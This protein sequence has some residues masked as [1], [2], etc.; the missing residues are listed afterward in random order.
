MSPSSSRSLS[1]EPSSA[2][3]SPRP[4][5]SPTALAMA[6]PRADPVRVPP[7]LFVPA[8]DP[9]P[10]LTG[11]APEDAEDPE[12]AVPDLLT[13]AALDPGRVV[14]DPVRAPPAEVLAAPVFVPEAC[15]GELC[16]VRAVAP[17][18]AAAVAPGAPVGSTVQFRNMKYCWPSVHRLVVTQ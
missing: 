15:R 7:D 4:S 14:A 17:V 11:R 18:V 13:W 10:A 3:S 5:D 6:S 1:R 9:L 2:T 12:D 16:A 8:V